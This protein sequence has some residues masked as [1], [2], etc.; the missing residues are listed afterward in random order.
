MQRLTSPLQFTA[1]AY[2]D[3]MEKNKKEDTIL[4]VIEDV[5]TR[6]NLSSRLRSVGHGVEA[7]TSGFHTLH[8]L[9]RNNYD[10][11]IIIDDMEDMAAPEI[12]SLIRTLKNAQEL[13]ILYINTSGI[14][15]NEKDTLAA[16]AN[17]TLSTDKRFD[18]VVEKIKKLTSKSA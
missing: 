16:G 9:E 7:S 4:L 13:P 2:Y 8:L 15:E 11:V 3:R 17:D 12:S 18:L 14:A 10:L 1:K 6:N 5:K